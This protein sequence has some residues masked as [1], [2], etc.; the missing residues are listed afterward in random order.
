MTSNGIA[1]SVIA[2]MYKLPD[3]MNLHSIHV[4]KETMKKKSNKKSKLKM[5][6]QSNFFF[7]FFTSI[8]H[9]WRMLHINSIWMTLY[10]NFS[11]S[12]SQTVA[13]GLGDKTSSHS[14]V[15]CIH[16]FFR[17][18]HKDVTVFS[19]FNDMKKAKKCESEK[20]EE[21]SILYKANQPK[22]NWCNKLFQIIDKE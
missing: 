12:W 14:F 15:S 6:L 18:K 1:M 19:S 2:N 11:W 4:K 5:L 22:R 3:T 16:T 10:N 17:S 13:L 9:V 8:D 7:C 21:K 20:S